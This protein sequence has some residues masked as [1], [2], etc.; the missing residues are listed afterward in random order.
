L[1]LLELPKLGVVLSQLLVAR[2]S[3]GGSC[4]CDLKDFL[5]DVHYLSV[6][7][8]PLIFRLQF[9]DQILEFKDL[10][11]KEV[12]AV[13]KVLRLFV[14]RCEEIVHLL[15]QPGFKVVNRLLL[16]LVKTRLVAPGEGVC[17][18]GLGLHN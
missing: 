12:G 11:L 18:D 17:E 7:V 8:L 2:D 4:L 15:E 16:F 14:D 3:Q 6:I 13:F 5:L 1:L 9:F 10:L